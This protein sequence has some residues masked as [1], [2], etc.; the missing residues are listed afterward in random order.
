MLN[1]VRLFVFWKKRIERK[2]K[3]EGGGGKGWMQSVTLFTHKK[4]AGKN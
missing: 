3:R 2:K 4:I 1:D